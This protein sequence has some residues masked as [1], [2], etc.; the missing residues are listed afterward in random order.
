MFIDQTHEDVNDD[1]EHTEKINIDDKFRKDFDLKIDF[2]RNKIIKYSSKNKIERTCESYGKLSQYIYELFDFIWTTELSIHS[3]LII[4]EDF[5]CHEIVWFNK[6]NFENNNFDLI[7]EIFLDI[8]AKNLTFILPVHVI[9]LAS[10]LNVLTPSSE[11]GTLQLDFLILKLVKLFQ[12]YPLL[13]C[14]R[15]VV[16][17]LC[18]HTHCLGSIPRVAPYKVFTVLQIVKGL[19]EC[20]T[21]MEIASILCFLVKQIKAAQLPS[22]RYSDCCK[23]K[24]PSSMM[25]DVAHFKLTKSVVDSDIKSEDRFACQMRKLGLELSERY[26]TFDHFHSS[27]SILHD[28]DKRTSLSTKM[29]NE[30]EVWLNILYQEGDLL[31]GAFSELVTIH[32]S[33]VK[34]GSQQ[35]LRAKGIL[36]ELICALSSCSTDCPSADNI[37]NTQFS[38]YSIVAA[39]D[40]WS[41]LEYILAVCIPLGLAKSLLLISTALFN[42]V[43]LMMQS[44]NQLQEVE[45][46]FVMELLSSLQF[47]ISILSHCTF[48]EEEL[49]GDFVKLMCHIYRLLHDVTY[50]NNISKALQS[51]V[52]SLVGYLTIHKIDIIG[53]HIENN[54]TLK[55]FF[56]SLFDVDEEEAMKV[57]DCVFIMQPVIAAML[58][59]HC[60]SVVG[61]HR[62]FRNQYVVDDKLKYEQS[63]LSLLPDVRGKTCGNTD[64]N[65]ERLNLCNYLKSIESNGKN[66]LSSIQEWA[67]L[68]LPNIHNC[69]KSSTSARH[70]VEHCSAQSNQELFHFSMTSQVHKKSHGLHLDAW[71]IVMTFLNVKRIGRLSCACKTTYDASRQSFIWELSYKRRFSSLVFA[72]NAK[73]TDDKCSCYAFKNSLV[74][75]SSTP[76][77][78]WIHLTKDRCKA[79]YCLARKFTTFSEKKLCPVVGCTTYLSHEDLARKHLRKHGFTEKMVEK[80]VKYQKHSSSTSRGSRKLQTR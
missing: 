59:S 41:I 37:N 27:S 66:R 13:N 48:T 35:Q 31:S 51:I 15:Y 63:V 3:K 53:V 65:I 54:S 28:G 26:E 38:L 11:I 45:D 21:A 39:F 22:F 24:R 5:F 61:I 20:L 57:N 58:T 68:L 77:H 52:A 79:I 55:Y 46:L 78:N 25:M 74:C 42:K 2:L 30:F 64:L 7:A 47:C 6:R 36:C 9:L 34:N 17:K 23:V 60:L 50:T 71:V 44:I 1:I 12:L 49:T 32:G 69:L 33:L 70:F 67:Q 56:Y 76:H 16:S 10:A 75:S 40:Y 14:S 73:L 8:A 80:L 4:L 18:R 19:E 62:K 72:P 43:E 29:L